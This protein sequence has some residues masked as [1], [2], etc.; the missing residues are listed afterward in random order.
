MSVA[1]KPAS[2]KVRIRSELENMQ[3]DEGDAGGAVGQHA[4]RPDD[5]DGVAERRGICSRP[6]SAGRAPRR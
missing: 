5:Q 1:I 2:P 6:R 4:G 3:G